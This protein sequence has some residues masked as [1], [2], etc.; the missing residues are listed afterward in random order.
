MVQKLWIYV[1]ELAGDRYYVGKSDDPQKRFDEHLAGHGSAWTKKY[2]Q[3]KLIRTIPCTGLTHE[4]AVVKEMMIEHGIDMVRGGSYSNVMLT[5]MQLDMLEAEMRG[6][7]DAC[8]RCGRSGHW[9]SS[10]YAVRDVNGVFIKDAPP[11]PPKELERK[12]PTK[13]KKAI[14]AKPKKATPA[15]PQIAKA[16]TAPGFWKS[17]GIALAG[18]IAASEANVS[19]E[20]VDESDEDTDACFRCGR[21]GH[22]QADC[23]ASR[24]VDG[25]KLAK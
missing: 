21:A 3:K 22:W 2:K 11:E 10:C 16:E 25:S 23:Y 6:A 15:K 9:I 17:F 13:P 19:E 5:R 7:T 12:Q 14:P 18:A 8:M 24:H 20:D 4:D 1:L